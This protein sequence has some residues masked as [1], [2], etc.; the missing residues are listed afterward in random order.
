M[1]PR[2]TTFSIVR[3]HSNLANGHILDQCAV[4][5]LREPRPYWGDR[6]NTIDRSMFFSGTA[7]AAEDHL[8][9]AARRWF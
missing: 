8:P 1:P 7:L 2:C 4:I 9:T 6:S 3:C 5:P